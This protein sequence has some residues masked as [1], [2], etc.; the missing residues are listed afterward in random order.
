MR[1]LPVDSVLAQLKHLLARVD[2]PSRETMAKITLRRQLVFEWSESPD[3][4]VQQWITRCLAVVQEYYD[5][6]KRHDQGKME[7]QPGGTTPGGA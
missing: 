2:A 5:W 4:D 7:T 1:P 3:P 6:V